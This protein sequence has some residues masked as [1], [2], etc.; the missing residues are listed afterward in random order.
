MSMLAAT[1]ITEPPMSLLRTSWVSSRV[2]LLLCKEREPERSSKVILI[3]KFSSTFQTTVHQVSLPSLHHTCMLMTSTMPS[4]LCMRTKCTMKWSC[5]LKLVKVDPCSRESLPQILMSMLPL[6]L[7][8][9][10]VLG[11]LTAT[12]M[13]LLMV[14]TL[15]HVWET[16]IQLTG[17]KIQTVMTL[18]LK[19]YQNNSTLLNKWPPNLMSWNMVRHHSK[20]NQL[21]TL[22]ETLKTMLL[23]QPLILSSTTWKQYLMLKLNTHTKI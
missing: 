17:W 16:S 7:M 8:P 6:H 18:Q 23:H 11:D 4:T 22:K 21:V 10:K 15:T 12:L 9:L 1:L 20:V 14:F 3:A 2:M 13:M 19:L 5:T